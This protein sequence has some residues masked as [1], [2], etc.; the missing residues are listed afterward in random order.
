ME[1]NMYGHDDE[2]FD[3]GFSD[4]RSP[5]LSLELPAGET[6][7]VNGPRL[8]PL[9]ITISNQT[10]RNPKRDARMLSSFLSSSLDDETVYYL[11]E[12]LFAEH[13]APVMGNDIKQMLANSL[14]TK[15]KTPAPARRK[16]QDTDENKD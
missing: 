12:F 2:D 3:G 1:S 16:K 15:I 13:I 10:E 11:A 9:I 4:P 6:L 5:I 7:Q 14:P 8:T